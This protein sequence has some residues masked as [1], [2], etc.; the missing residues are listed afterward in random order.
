VLPLPLAQ[1]VAA[2][3]GH[4]PDRAVRVTSLDANGGDRFTLGTYVRSGRRWADLLRGL[5]AVVEARGIRLPGIDLVTAAD[6]PARKGLGSSAAF[7][8]ACLRAFFGAAG[9]PVE[10]RTA[11]EIV[12][13]VEAEWAGVHCGAMDP[14]VAAAG[15]VG[16]PLLLDCQ[17]LTHEE[18]PWP[19]GV[20]AVPED[21]GISR[22]LSSTP[23]DAR[24]KELERGLDHVRAAQPGA[25]SLRELDARSLAIALEEVPDPAR[26]RVRHAIT[27]VARV[28]L[29]ADALRASDAAALGHVLDEGHKSLSR[30]FECSSPEIDELVKERRTEPGVLGVRLQGAGWGGCLVVLRKKKGDVPA[31]SGHA[32]AEAP[33]EADAERLA[34]V[35]LE[36]RTDARS[37]TRGDG[38]PRH[39][40]P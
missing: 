35:P 6:L 27:E 18:L 28:G 14:Y 8:V 16:K 10:P 33:A 15:V 24:R 3:W 31:P 13:A 34:D 40:V 26:R 9:R 19:P 5:C 23:Y 36:E 4:R 20:E 38:A 21:T 32:G 37:L 7:L 25:R 30:D 22:E 39:W 2:A 29:A 1:G 12:Q 11:A 17:A